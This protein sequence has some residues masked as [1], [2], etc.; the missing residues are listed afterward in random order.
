M[1]FL[2][3]TLRAEVGDTIEVVFKNSLRYPGG[4]CRMQLGVTHSRGRVL[5]FDCEF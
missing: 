3:P 4:C 1:G 5:L 2:G